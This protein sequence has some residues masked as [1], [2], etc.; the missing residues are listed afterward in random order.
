M[1]NDIFLKTLTETLVCSMKCTS[2][3]L[4]KYI[5]FQ[6]KTRLFFTCMELT[7]VRGT[8]GP[9]ASG[10]ADTCCYCSLSATNLLVYPHE[11]NKPDIALLELFHQTCQ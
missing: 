6:M 3:K 8:C 2:T 5:F 4:S 9:A 11:A 1:P 7:C 10:T